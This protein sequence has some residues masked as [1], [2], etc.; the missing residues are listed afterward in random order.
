LFQK[1]QIILADEGESISVQTY[2]DR[3]NLKEPILY[4]VPIGENNEIL[5][6]E[7]AVELE[8]IVNMDVVILNAGL[9]GVGDFDRRA[10]EKFLCDTAEVIED[11]F[12]PS[13]YRK[14]L[15]LNGIS[16]MEQPIM[17]NLRR[18]SA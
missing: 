9:F 8:K 1:A 15:R 5:M 2:A 4:L 12:E 13:A 7:T 6:R 16:T 18:L 3:N 11:W 10:S 17:I 14:L